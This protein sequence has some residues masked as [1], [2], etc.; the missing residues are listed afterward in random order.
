MLETSWVVSWS[1]GIKMSAV[2]CGF[3]LNISGVHYIFLLAG[4]FWLLHGFWAIAFAQIFLKVSEQ[5]AEGIK[6]LK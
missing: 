1:V 3:M 4:I 2:K 5:I 6:S